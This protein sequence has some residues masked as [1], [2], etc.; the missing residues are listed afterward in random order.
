MAS[1]RVL[2]KSFILNTVFFYTAVYIIN[3]VIVFTGPLININGQ[4]P[5]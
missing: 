5:S 3:A 4:S 2:S 1:K